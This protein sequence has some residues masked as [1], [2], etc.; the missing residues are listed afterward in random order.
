[1]CPLCQRTTRD[2]QLFK[3]SS[4][5][6]FQLRFRAGGPFHANSIADDLTKSFATFFRYPK[7]GLL[8]AL[9]FL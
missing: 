5:D 6:V 4:R 7:D 9:N 1:M 8:R 3:D 2:K